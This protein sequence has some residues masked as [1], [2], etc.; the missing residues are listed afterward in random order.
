[1][2]MWRE[3]WRQDERHMISIIS[4]ST[5][6]LF[7]SLTWRVIAS[8]VDTAFS[9][10]LRGGDD[11]NFLTLLDIQHELLLCFI[12]FFLS[13][14][15]NGEKRR[16]KNLK[17]NA[18]IIIIISFSYIYSFSL[19]FHILRWDISLRIAQPAMWRV[20]GERDRN[21]IKIKQSREA[22]SL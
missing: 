15:R 2:W 19:L 10:L 21:L 3:K 22:V 14:I 9:L 5:Y 8:E 17:L 20:E 12:F 4:Q 13:C 16:K 11:D 18:I 6:S 7:I 1:M